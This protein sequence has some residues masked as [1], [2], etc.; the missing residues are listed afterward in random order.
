M[1]KELLGLEIVAI[2]FVVVF[3]GLI[4]GLNSTIIL[5]GI[6]MQAQNLEFKEAFCETQGFDKYE[7][8]ACLKFNNG[9]ATITELHCE[10]QPQP[11]FW[12]FDGLYKKLNKCRTVIKA[13]E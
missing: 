8:D 10:G 9:N 1:E 5:V 13:V 11:G 6:P 12:M 4:L 3:V 2:C 7:E